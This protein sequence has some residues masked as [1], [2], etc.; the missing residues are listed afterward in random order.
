MGVDAASLRF[1]MLAAQTGVRF[2]RTLMLGRQNLHCAPWEIDLALSDLGRSCTDRD[3]LSASMP[4]AE[5][6]FGW[7]GA[8]QVD[9]M[10]ASDYE[11]ATIV[12]S[13]NEPIPPELANQ[14]TLVFDGGTLE[15]VF[16]VRVAWA[17][18]ME[19]VAPG[20]H[21]ISVT[22][23]NNHL[24]HGFYQFSPELIFRVFSAENGFELEGVFL[25]EQ[26]S[27][28]SDR[29]EVFE[30]RDPAELGRRV[31][32]VNS[33]S[34]LML[35]RAR[36]TAAVKPFEAPAI[37]SDY[38]AKWTETSTSTVRASSGLRERIRAARSALRRQARPLDRLKHGILAA[39]SPAQY[40]SEAFT[41]WVLNASMKSRWS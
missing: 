21:L 27:K 6:L 7:L 20:G 23:A 35:I 11:S 19:L 2:E 30:V 32:L 12:H 24:G 15:H 40:D 16:D 25:Y 4:Y 33:H 39:R 41:R 13:L 1:L 9:S 8:H 34:T 31:I 28:G 38:A 22:T 37:Q 14:F 10:D 29:S 36:K 26:T 5:S 18:A 3:A 17:N